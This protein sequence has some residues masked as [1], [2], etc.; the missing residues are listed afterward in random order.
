MREDNIFEP[1]IEDPSGKQ[2]LRTLI[3]LCREKICYAPEHYQN[4]EKTWKLFV[5]G[6]FV[7]PF[8]E[9]AYKHK[10]PRPKNFEELTEYVSNGFFVQPTFTVGMLCF[11]AFDRINNAKRFPY[12]ESVDAFFEETFSLSHEEAQKIVRDIRNPGREEQGKRK[13]HELCVRK[14]VSQKSEDMLYREFLRT[15]PTITKYEVAV[16]AARQIYQIAY[17]QANYPE[18]Y[19]RIKEIIIQNE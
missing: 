11:L 3:A 5:E 12:R 1:I 14:E 2:T 4:D 10:M 6:K 18:E 13:L 8:F 19:K 17:Y 15:R 7:C 9:P 16:F